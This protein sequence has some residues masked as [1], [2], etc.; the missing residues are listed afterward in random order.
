VGF[1]FKISAV[2]VHFW[3][4]DVYEGAPT[5]VAGY[6]STA[7]KAAGFAV[8][9]RV[10]LALFPDLEGNWPT[11]LAILSAAS[12]IVGNVLALV[13]KNVKRLLAYSSIAQA[14]Y[15]LAG[16]AAANAIGFSG[17][18]FYLISY[19]VTNLAAFGV[20]ALI[21][22]S[23]GS[24][25][26]PAY[27]GLHRRNPGL[28]WALLISL[29]S[30]GGIPPL[31]GFVGKLLVFGAAIQAG[32]V[33]LAIIGVLTSVVGLFYYLTVIK[34]AFTPPVGTAPKPLLVSTPWRVAII[35]CVI[36]IF[37]LGT[38]LGPLYGLSALGSA[39][40]FVP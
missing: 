19:L 36:G 32:M 27:M 38:V 40:L 12:M 28:A 10:M 17:T 22:R 1:G 39:A 34:A 8:L 14:G 18:V 9:M 13:Q 23:T 15:I 37:V 2:P 5:P 30:L 31:G 24:D 7:S 4:P 20:V 16:V 35:A 21:G 3:A 29:L 11:L 26:L 6:L 33:W 25:E